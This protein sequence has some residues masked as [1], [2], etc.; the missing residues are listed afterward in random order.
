MRCEKRP[1]T[2]RIWTNHLLITK[3]ALYTCATTAAPPKSLNKPLRE[4]YASKQSL[5]I[6]GLHSLTLIQSRPTIG[7][8]MTTSNNIYSI[9]VG[10]GQEVFLETSKISEIFSHRLKRLKIFDPLLTKNERR[11]VLIDFWHFWSKD[12]WN[13]FD[14]N[15]SWEGNSLLKKCE[16]FCDGWVVGVI[17]MVSPTP[18]CIQLSIQ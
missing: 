16:D 10:W 4:K 5:I 11:S 7:Q 12:E 3:H 14:K 2:V 15:F 17:D 1:A 6:K 8:P 13:Q 18:V 9:K